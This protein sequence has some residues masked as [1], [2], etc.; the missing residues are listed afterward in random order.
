MEYNFNKGNRMRKIEC[1][2]RPFKLEKV[3]E[4][5]S[6]VGVRSM[7]VSEVRG[8]RRGRR[9]IDLYP[10]GED[11]IEV[12]PKLKVEIV[13]PSEDVNKVVEAV[14]QAATTNNILRD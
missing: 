5:L 12:A 1:V 8:F 13:V 6:S 7:T 14:K 9:Y 10:I 3:Q 2:I 11:T 4:A